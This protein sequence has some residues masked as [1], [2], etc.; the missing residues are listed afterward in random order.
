MKRKDLYE[1][2]ANIYLDASSSRR[3]KFREFSKIF[4]KV[5]LTTSVLAG[6]GLVFFNLYSRNQSLNNNIA[7][8]L[9]VEPV[10]INFHFDPAKKEIYTVDLK[11]MDLTRFRALAFTVKKTDYRGPMNLR[12]EF[13]NRFRER[14]EIYLKDIPYRWKEYRI[15]LSQFRKISNWLDMSSLSFIVEEWNV[16]QKRGI[17]YL[18]NIRFIR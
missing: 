18:D 14:S 4:Q 12:V 17:V 10:K 8:V 2:L 11:S 13:T 16:S 6:L 1:H 7:L 15:D 5:L 3:K 9:C